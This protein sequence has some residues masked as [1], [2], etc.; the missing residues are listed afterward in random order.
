VD[1]YFYKHPYKFYPVVEREELVGCVSVDDVKRLPKQEWP[2]HS[3]RELAAPCN[4]QNT[5]RPDAEAVEALSTMSH[6]NVSRLMV[7]DHGRLLGV[8]A[9]KD[10][11]NFLSRKLELEPETA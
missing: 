9:L 5:I 1:N 11:M 3:A 4:R 7:V 8:V 6:A 2:A 10:L